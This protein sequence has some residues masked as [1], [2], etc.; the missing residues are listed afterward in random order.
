M[1]LFYI[2]ACSKLFKKCYTTFSETVSWDIANDKCSYRN[3]HLVTI[4]SRNEMN[5]LQY[6]LRNQTSMTL[7][8]DKK[9]HG[10]HIGNYFVYIKRWANSMIMILIDMVQFQDLLQRV[11]K[12]ELYIVEYCRKHEEMNT[13]VSFTVIPTTFLEIR[14]L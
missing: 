7:K 2:L 9:L 8:N 14:S 10:A 13:N 3:E 12:Y 11:F 5:Y 4:T 6:L 1:E